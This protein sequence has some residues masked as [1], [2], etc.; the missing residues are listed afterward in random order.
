[1]LPA[2]MNRAQRRA[3]ERTHRNGVRSRA[4][5]LAAGV[6]IAGLA[7]AGAMV[8]AS[9]ANAA[10]FQVTSS[11]DSGSGTLRAAVASAAPG[12]TITFAPS[13]TSIVLSSEIEIN[14]P[15]TISGPGAGALT[16]DGNSVTRIFDIESVSGGVTLSGLTLSNATAEGS[17]GGA[18]YAGYVGQLTLSAM[19]FS[20]NQASRNGGGIDAFHTNLTVTDST[21]TGNAAGAAIGESGESDGNGG[22]I[23]A[24]T[25]GG[26]NGYTVSITGSTFSGDTADNGGAVFGYDLAGMTV[27]GSTFNANLASSE[28]GG[29]FALDTPLAVSGSQFT[30]NTASGAGGGLMVQTPGGPTTIDSSAFTGNS[31]VA[32]ISGGAGIAVFGAGDQTVKITA[33]AISGN[34]TL[35]AGGGIASVFSIVDIAGSSISGNSAA[36]G[37]GLAGLI[38]AF[39]L[40]DSSLAA[41]SATIAGGGVVT[42]DG[43]FARAGLVSQAIGQS[44]EVLGTSLT[45]S[46]VSGNTAPDGAAVAVGDI[47]NPQTTA[48][49]SSLEIAPVNVTPE[50]TQGE[51]AAPLAVPNTSLALLA[52]DPQA[53]AIFNALLVVDSTVTNNTS[54]AGSAIAAGNYAFVL[55]DSATVAQNTGSGAAVSLDGSSSAGSANS[56][57]WNPASHGDF[58]SAAVLAA[59]SL[60][61]A[62]GAAPVAN[63]VDG[64]IVGADPQLGALANNGGSTGTLLPAYTSP[65]IDAGNNEFLTVNA[66]ESSEVTVGDGDQRGLPRISGPTTAAAA[67][68]NTDIGAV[69]VQ[70]S[71]PSVTDPTS[72]TK[73]DGDSVSFTATCSGFADPTI[74]WQSSVDGGASWVTVSGATT[75]TL[76]FAVSYSQTGFQFRAVCTNIDGAVNSNAATL[77]VNAM[78]A[79][80][81]SPVE[82]QLPVAGGLIAFGGVLM[83]LARRRRRTDA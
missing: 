59:S 51:A 58:D 67:T 70:Y 82:A 31:T 10:T 75:G 17:W 34:S 23:S 7:A 62:P 54:S 32:L 9:P 2:G 72:A 6:G 81:G 4:T 21:F 24:G 40:T 33:T 16:I 48:L 53:I 14:E 27:S 65:L 60:I 55:L 74:S 41:N 3:S 78:L 80:T 50:G 43:G 1:M 30:G 35:G 29:A 66:G 73:N 42:Y 68:W 52:S 45:R 44:P 11:A 38:S 47:G 18:I 37:G 36:E 63:G 22:A 39:A 57:L 71:L 19:T 8:T 26:G 83:G 15:L 46:T 12:D 64:N 61:G 13:V 28:G 25:H 69:E 76:T 49:T 77:T 79:S 20:G 5:R 56:A